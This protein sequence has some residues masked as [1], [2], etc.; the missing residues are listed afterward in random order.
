MIG[1][2]PL[3]E[4]YPGNWLKKPHLNLPGKFDHERLEPMYAKVFERYKKND[5]D[6]I[7]YFEPAT[8]PDII[9]HNIITHAGFEKPPGADIGSPN[10]VLND[11]TYCCQLSHTV[12][13]TGEPSLNQTKEC[14][15]WHEK[16]IGKRD[17]DAA[18]LGVPLIISEFGACLTEQPC[19]QEIRQVTEVSD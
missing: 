12:C 11:H 10:H 3:N 8:Y 18:R 5:P 6:S 17:G 1:F 15:D 13:E 19:T 9:K 4:P 14:F 7:M 16:R 2:D